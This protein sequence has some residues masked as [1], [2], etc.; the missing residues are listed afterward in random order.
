MKIVCSLLTA[1][2]MVSVMEISGQAAFPLYGQRPPAGQVSV[3]PAA[4]WPFQHDFARELDF[5]SLNMQFVGNWPAGQSFS[6]DSSP[7]GDT[8]FVG[9]GGMVIVLDVTDPYNPLQI[10]EIRARA[11][12]DGCYYDPAGQRLILAAYF[13]GVEVW[14]VSDFSDPSMICRIPTNSYPRGGVFARGNY[15]YIVTVADG[16]YIADISNPGAPVMVGHYPISSGTLVWDSDFSGDFAFLAASNG[17]LKAIDFSDPADPVLAGSFSGNASGISVR[18]TLAFIVGSN[19]VLRLINIGDPAAMTLEGYCN[20]PGSPGRITVSGDYAYVA[21]FSDDPGG[22]NVVDVS[23]P[24]L[25]VLA[26]SFGGYQSYIAGR[27]ECIGATGGAEGCLILDIS[28]PLNPATAY[29]WPLAGFTYK[30]A[31]SGELA[32]TGSNGFRVFDISGI[33]SPVQ[34]GFEP[35]P[36]ALVAIKDTLAV[37]IDKSMTSNNPVNVMNIADPENPVNFG[38]YLS[39]VMT[40]DLALYGEYAFVACWWD[41]VRVI[42]ISDPADP[43]LAAH[44]FGWFTG[45]E[46]GVDFCYVQALDIYGHYLYLA[47]YQP[48]EGEDTKG[49]YIFDITDPVEPSLLSRYSLLTSSAQDIRAWGDYVYVADG[50]GGCE[51]INVSDPYL[52]YTSGYCSLPDGATGVDISWP[53]VYLSDY[54]FGGVQ[55]VDV[56]V[57]ETPFVTAYYKPSGVFAQGVTVNSNYVMVGDGVCGFQVYDLLTATGVKDPPQLSGWGLSVSPNPARATRQVSFKLKEPSAISLVLSDALGRTQMRIIKGDFVAG[58][59]ALT[60]SDQSLS[61]GLYYITLQAG[62]E[63]ETVKMIVE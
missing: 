6:I 12:I 31:V 32:Y 11:L 63:F 42:D 26:A 56:S 62:Q 2:L 19:Q 13:S 50:N 40:W 20:L 41:G 23:D 45:A 8:L 1:L 28:N 49:L 35:T 43:V 57:P 25:P 54:I 30:V 55:V 52:P 5:D 33:G 21:N 47:D 9:S 38:N 59:H 51:V 37:Y 4:E 60:F 34:I 61:P 10:G 22:V 48:F 17:G 36:G 14:D 39:P 24:A 29:A 27:G 3:L 7:T 58:A 18:D 44:A 15:V 53:F 16:F 46:P